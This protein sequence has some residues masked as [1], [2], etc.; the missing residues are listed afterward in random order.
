MLAAHRIKARR[1]AVGRDMSPAGFSIIAGRSDRRHHR[2]RSCA[3]RLTRKRHFYARPSGWISGWRKANSEIGVISDNMLPH[4][5]DHIIAVESVTVYG[6]AKLSAI[7]DPSQFINRSLLAQVP[8]DVSLDSPVISTLPSSVLRSEQLA[9]GS[10][11]AAEELHSVADEIH[12][13]NPGD[14]T[15]LTAMVVCDG[16]CRRLVTYV[17]IRNYA[18]ALIT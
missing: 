8:N 6:K 12:N 7:V 18:A 13:G 10:T 5:P 17:Y 14:L 15:V 3:L 11:H 1:R 9:L 2:W 4:G 16:R